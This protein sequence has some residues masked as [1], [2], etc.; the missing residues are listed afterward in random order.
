[1]RLQAPKTSCRLLLSENPGI[2]TGAR[3]NPALNFH[4][5]MRP[6]VGRLWASVG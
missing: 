5:L 3:V 1:M 6:D 2:P 4:H